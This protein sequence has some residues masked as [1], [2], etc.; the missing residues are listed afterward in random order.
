MGGGVEAHQPK[1][2]KWKYNLTL[3][4]VCVPCAPPHTHTQWA[5]NCVRK[6]ILVHKHEDMGKVNANKKMRRGE[7][8]KRVDS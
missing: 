8:E 5:R 1:V 3:L 6:N 7:E 2:S 4:C